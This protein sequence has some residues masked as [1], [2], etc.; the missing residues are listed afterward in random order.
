LLLLDVNVVVAAHR[1]DHQHYAVAGTWFQDLLA[2]NTPFSVPLIVWASFL[3]LVTN[4]RIFDPPTPLEDAFAFLEGTCAQP[5]YLLLHPGPDHL[6][7]LRRICVEANATA[8]LVPDAV[9]AAIALEHGAVVASLDRDFA[10]FSSI[11]YVVPG[12]S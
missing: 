3:R 2:G 9:I 10:R 7:L 12:S 1:D 8:D 5:R 11:K 6:R 4:R